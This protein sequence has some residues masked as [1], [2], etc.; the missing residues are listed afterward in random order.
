MWCEISK[1]DLIAKARDMRQ[2]CI[3]LEDELFHLCG[4]APD[5]NYP[6]CLNRIVDAG[7]KAAE[8]K[9]LEFKKMDEH[10]EMMSRMNTP[11]D[12]GHIMIDNNTL[13]SRVLVMVVAVRLVGGINKE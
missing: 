5:F 13:H 6:E 2:I 10:D 1:E 4:E 11:E 7:M 9:I 12:Y 3:D 8:A